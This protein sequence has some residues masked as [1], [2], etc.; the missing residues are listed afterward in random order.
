MKRPDE[1]AH[2]LGD[3][4]DPGLP[5]RVRSSQEAGLLC[6][7]VFRA[8]MWRQWGLRKQ[9]NRRP[10]LGR[11]VRTNPRRASD[12]RSI[13][14]S[15]LT[16]Q[17][18]SSALCATDSAKRRAGLLDPKEGAYHRAILWRVIVSC[19]CFRI[20]RAVV[21]TQE[22]SFD[23]SGPRPCKRPITLGWS[24]SQNSSPTRYALSSDTFRQRIG[25]D[26]FEIHMNAMH[27]QDQ[28]RGPCLLL[29]N[30]LQA[31]Q[32]SLAEAACV[33]V[34]CSKEGGSISGEQLLQHL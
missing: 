26:Q 3:L 1:Q 15:T 29:W 13:P 25:S 19:P 4:T 8:Q 22:E 14:S 16:R 20:R 9:R 34:L 23:H 27:L 7:P 10:F 18:S 11:D 6:T 5:R 28:E 31:A 2:L 33:G 12:E 17:R 30:L 24:C 21:V 32:G